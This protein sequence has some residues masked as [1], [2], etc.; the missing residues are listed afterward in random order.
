MNTMVLTHILF[1]FISADGNL[2]G[3]PL[4]RNDQ[5]DVVSKSLFTN[6]IQKQLTT[7]PLDFSE[8]LATKT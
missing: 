5:G 8:C 1:K 7:T 3:E 6:W 4:A 2:H